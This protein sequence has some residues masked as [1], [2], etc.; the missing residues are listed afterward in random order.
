MLTKEGRE[1]TCGA[2]LPSS[3]EEEEPS[4]EPVMSFLMMKKMRPRLSHATLVN[5]RNLKLRR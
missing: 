3:H 1:P 2:A 4:I 5:S